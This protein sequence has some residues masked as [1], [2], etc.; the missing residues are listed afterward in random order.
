MFPVISSL[1]KI[2]RPFPGGKNFR[3][4]P[5][6]GPLWE[7]LSRVLPLGILVLGPEGKIL[8]ANPKTAEIHG[9]PAEEILNR[10]FAEILDPQDHEKG[11]EFF[12]GLKARTS[13]ELVARLPHPEKKHIWVRISGTTLE[14]HNFLIFLTDI[15]AQ[16][17]LEK[18]LEEGRIRYRSLFQYTPMG[19]M[20]F[21]LASDGSGPVI[22]EYNRAAEKMIDTE[23]QDL[24]GERFNKIFPYWFESLWPVIQQISS[25]GV[26]QHLGPTFVSELKMPGWYEC[27][28]YRPPNGEIVC[29]FDNVT[30]RKRAE[31]D[32]VESEKKYKD[33]VQNLWE[34]IWQLDRTNQTVFVNQR[35][36]E[37]LGYKITEMLG[38]SIEN[39]FDEEMKKCFQQGME[40]NL[41]TSVKEWSPTEIVFL[42]KDGG[43]LYTSISA[44]PLFGDDGE[45]LGLLASITDISLRVSLEKKQ[46]ELIKGLEEK[47]VELERFIYTVSHDLKSP[48][49]TIR[50]FLGLLKEDIHS[51]RIEDID[52][53]ILRINNAADKMYGLLTDLLELSRI[54]RIGPPPEKFNLNEAIEEVLVLLQGK[55]SERKVKIN[56]P[57]AMPKVYA[58]KKRVQEIFQNLVENALKFMGPQ[59]DPEINIDARIEN[60]KIHCLVRDNGIGIEPPYHEKIFNLFERLDHNVPGTGVGLAIVKRIVEVHK[61]NVWVESQGRGNGSTFHFTLPE[62]P[63]SVTKDLQ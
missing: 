6:E 1:R 16:K 53:N 62:T 32:L 56:I 38:R 48:L 29:I 57:P 4:S 35:M 19:V 17:E 18:N 58:E 21:R 44:R 60:G 52:K 27:F 39:F 43:P 46:E 28:I 34:G 54:G 45:Y 7:T 24:I 51:S 40:K 5:A 11:R 2:F 33:L 12:H 42:K 49:I 30:D 36:A 50:G 37:M 13:L 22:S 26:A 10:Q 15:N 14:D 59:Q 61:G 47:N 8:R 41:K 3:S 31:I 9:H 25:S 20:I 63:E 55:L 23:K